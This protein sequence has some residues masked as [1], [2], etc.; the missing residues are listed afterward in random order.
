[1]MPDESPLDRLEELLADRALE[2]L[3]AEELAELDRL[4]GDAETAGLELELAAASAALAIER[5]ETEELPPALSRR[6]QADAER[7]FATSAPAAPGRSAVMRVVPWLGWV[8]AAASLLVSVRT[9]PAPT[10]AVGVTREVP[11]MERL[12][13]IAPRPLA[14][15]DHRLAQGGGGTLVWSDAKQEG[16]LAI[17]GLAETD[18]ARGVY[19]LWIFDET[20]DQ[21]FP[22]DGGTFSIRDSRAT[23]TVPFRPRLEVRRPTLFAITLEPAGGVVVSDR[24]RL[25]LTAAYSP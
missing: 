12:A 8:A 14:P 6:L 2:G 21:R 15:T 1:M 24:K 18:P 4:C 11:L 10:N 20:R 19:Q 5:G 23:T 25:L 7:Y 16:Y 3:T 9:A 22:V 17:R 13:G